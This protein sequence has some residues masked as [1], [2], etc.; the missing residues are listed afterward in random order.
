[1]R[2][3]NAN[4][5]RFSFRWDGRQIEAREGDSIAAALYAA[6]HRVLARSRK[7]HRPR[8]LSGS[9][10]AGVLGRVDGWPHQR[11]DAVAALPGMD[12][13]SQN[14]WPSANFDLLAA[15]RLVPR[16]WLRGGFEHP[17]FL[18]SG[19]LRFALWEKLLRQV[20]GVAGAPDRAVYGAPI[21]GRR[22]AADVVVVGGG[23]AGRDEA[24]RAAAMDQSVVLI[25]RGDPP[26][27]LGRAGGRDLTPIAEGVE[28]LAGHEC[29]ALYRDGAMVCCAPRD[30]TGGAVV[31]DAGRLVLA[32]GRRS[33]PP[34]VPG[35]DLPGVMDVHAAVALAHDY[36]V[37]PGRQVAVLGL[38]AE[39][40]ASHL[41]TLGVT[42]VHRGPLE[43]LRAIAGISEV[44]GIHLD[45]LVGCDAVVH[46][47]PWRTDPVLPFQ[48]GAEGVYR[49]LSNGPGSNVTMAGDA[50]LA[51]DPVSL[52]AGLNR[53]ALVCPCMDVTV[54]EVLDL[55]A[56]GI[57][58]VEEIKRL[59]ACGMGPCQ[60]VPCWDQLA[61][62][63][64]ATSGRPVASFGN[65]TYR[66]PRAGLTLAQA[67]GLHG[68]V[69]S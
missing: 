32:L 14:A 19:T 27:A 24:A 42:V 18:P 41:A 66:P 21:P 7:F 46:A 67:A 50:G 23:P 20:A 25:S 28:V 4:A 17:N 64:A 48:A 51:P 49:V 13:R 62:T 36:G 61:A 12:V 58:H 40:T 69:G 56:Q 39:A 2:L 52:G 34:L 31:I 11:L 16:A 1:M 63:L 68:L 47:G 60:G 6:G 53:R 5:N 35:A 15:T 55:V 37:A 26:G 8:G 3:H 38:A 59:T 45:H 30:G 9:F 29:F 33:F 65:P 57:D 43:E 44:S 54:A 10:V 22:M